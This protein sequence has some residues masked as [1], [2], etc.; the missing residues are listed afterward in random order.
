MGYADDRVQELS[1]PNLKLKRGL[2]V[3]TV[4]RHVNVMESSAQSDL[5]L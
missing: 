1:V 3:W 4:R 2:L 5:K